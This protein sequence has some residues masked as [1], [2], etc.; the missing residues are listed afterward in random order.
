MRNAEDS[1]FRLKISGTKYLRVG[2]VAFSDISKVKVGGY[3]GADLSAA[4]MGTLAVKL[5]I[6][7]ADGTKYCLHVMKDYAAF[8]LPEQAD[9]LKRMVEALQDSRDG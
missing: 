4:L 7:L 2:P 6:N 9:S 8:G 5:K 1:S 3:S